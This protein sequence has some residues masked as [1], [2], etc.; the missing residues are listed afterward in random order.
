MLVELAAGLRVARGLERAF[1]FT[2]AMQKTIGPSAFFV[3]PPFRLFARF[4]KFDDVTH[5]ELGHQACEA[6]Q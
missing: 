6:L 3:A 2:S 4:T 5:P 1:G